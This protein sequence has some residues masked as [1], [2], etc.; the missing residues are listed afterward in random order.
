MIKPSRVRL[1]RTS[2][3]HCSSFPLGHTGRHS[4]FIINYFILE[5]LGDKVRYDEPDQPEP[6]LKR[7][8]FVLGCLTG[9]MQTAAWGL[10]GL[11]AFRNASASHTR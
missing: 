1:K 3:R 6:P 5:I 8:P 10:T 4:P 7:L 11:E 2:Q 9:M